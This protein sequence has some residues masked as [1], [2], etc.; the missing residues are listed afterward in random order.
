MSITDAPYRVNVSM[1][2]AEF[3]TL[4][5]AK[6]QIGKRAEKSDFD[7]FKLCVGCLQAQVKGLHFSSKN[8]PCICHSMATMGRMGALST[9]TDTC[10]VHLWDCG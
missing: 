4:K 7:L 8:N 10:Q 1:F 6:L 9:V 3:L 2:R 5:E